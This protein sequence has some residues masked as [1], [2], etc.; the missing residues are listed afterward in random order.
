[1][2]CSLRGGGGGNFSLV[3]IFPLPR[4][5][6]C[7][8]T[9]L[10]PSRKAFTQARPLDVHQSMKAERGTSILLASRY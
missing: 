1:M 3:L 4:V 9:H 2:S 5:Y 6:K 8:P 10:S 7:G